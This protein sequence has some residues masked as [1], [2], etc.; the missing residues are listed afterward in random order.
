MFPQWDEFLTIK[1]I[2]QQPPEMDEW[3]IDFETYYDKMGI[4]Y[5]PT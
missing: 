1:T 2:N 5:I 3:K 4:D